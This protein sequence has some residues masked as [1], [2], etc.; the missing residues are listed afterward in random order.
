LHLEPGVTFCAD[1]ATAG[2]REKAKE[3][4]NPLARLAL[5]RIPEV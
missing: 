4:S 3:I 1:I 2:I 5:I